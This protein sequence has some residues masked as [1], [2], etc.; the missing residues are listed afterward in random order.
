[1]K[2]KDIHIFNWDFYNKLSVVTK[3]G[4]KEANPHGPSRPAFKT[5]KRYTRKVDIFDKEMVIVPIIEK[6]HWY[7][8]VILKPGAILK[9]TLA[10]AGSSSSGRRSRCH[11]VTE[12]QKEAVLAGQLEE[13]K[14]Q[15]EID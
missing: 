11:D 4:Y 12:A 10:A 15:E 1:M 2:R 7:H 13:E 9:K 3:P 5:I 6:L 14:R 8:A